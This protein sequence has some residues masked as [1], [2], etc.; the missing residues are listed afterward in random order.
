MDILS[1][2]VIRLKDRVLLLDKDLEAHGVDVRKGSEW[3]LRFHRW[4]GRHYKNLKQGPGWS[5]PISSF[6][7]GNDEVVTNTTA[8][9][10]ADPIPRRVPQLPN[11][12]DVVVDKT[13]QLGYAIDIPDD[14]RR[15]FQHYHDAI[16]KQS[17]P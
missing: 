1:P 10:V 13:S 4:K 12:D 16:F 2:L 3:V 6:P 8:V 14:I 7:M 5:F 9:K 11:N 15:Y 17:L